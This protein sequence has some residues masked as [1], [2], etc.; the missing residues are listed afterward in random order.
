MALASFSRVVI[1]RSVSGR[2]RISPP[3]TQGPT[4]HGRA[5]FEPVD[6]LK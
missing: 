5:G 3:R 2:D 1:L 4:E 6:R